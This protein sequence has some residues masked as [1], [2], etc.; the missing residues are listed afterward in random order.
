MSAL[1]EPLDSHGNR[2]HPYVS[3][4]NTDFGYQMANF[5]IEYARKTWPSAKPEEIG[6][7]SMDF[8]L[9]PQVHERTTGANEI[10]LKEGYLKKNFVVADGAEAAD[11][12]IQGGY[13]LAFKVFKANSKIK[14]WLVCAFYDDYAQGAAEAAAASGKQDSCV[15]VDCGGSALIAQWDSGITTCWKASVFAAQIIFTE[16]MFCGLYA[17]MDG[18]AT[19]ETL[20]P[21]WIDKNAGE[22]YAYVD[23]PTYILTKD[24]YKEYLEWVDSYTGVNLSDYPYNGTQFPSR[25]TPPT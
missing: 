3:F 1:A 11:L 17:M 15:V 13:D 6:M 19:A 18:Q 25:A 22:K 10:W 8:S 16:P 7:L 23:T 20:W 4:D 9:S 21:Q 12:S 5:T 14:Y 24:N 2:I